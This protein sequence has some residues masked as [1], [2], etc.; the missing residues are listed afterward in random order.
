MGNMNPL[1]S[2]II[3]TKKQRESNPC[4]YSLE[5]TVDTDAIGLV[6]TPF[7]ACVYWVII[8]CEV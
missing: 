6:L 1:R 7:T 2:D 4:V 8:E 3:T 5:Y